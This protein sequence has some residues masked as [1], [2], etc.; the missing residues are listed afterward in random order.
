MGSVNNRG[1]NHHQNS[2]KLWPLSLLVL[3]ILGMIVFLNGFVKERDGIHLT[4]NAT[5]LNANNKK[6]DVTKSLTLSVNSDGE[7]AEIR[8]DYF[9]N[10][11]PKGS[12]LLKGKLMRLE[13]AEMTYNFRF[14][15]GEVR[16][17][18]YQVSLPKHLKEILETGRK[19]LTH[20]KGVD[21]SMQVT[22]MD[23]SRGYSIVKF[24]PGNNIWACHTDFK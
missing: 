2:F 4:C 22:Q 24:E 7:Q 6:D 10:A 16:K 14:T 12:L 1:F 21:I 5:L 19:V 11:K 18:I 13:V 23:K 15:K 3:V 8:Y 9:A 20:S 17:D